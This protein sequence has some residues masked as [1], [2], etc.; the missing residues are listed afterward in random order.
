MQY[1]GEIGDDQNQDAYD[2]AEEDD[3]F[4]HCGAFVVLTHFIKELQKL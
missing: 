1:V 2:E 4:R 3:V